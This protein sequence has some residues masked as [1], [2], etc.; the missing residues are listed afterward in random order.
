MLLVGGKA[1][2]SLAAVVQGPCQLPSPPEGLT[3]ADKTCVTL[4]QELS[5]IRAEQGPGP[6]ADRV[7]CWRMAH[8][9][10]WVGACMGALRGLGA[11]VAWPVICRTGSWFA[12]GNLAP[13]PLSGGKWGTCAIF[14]PPA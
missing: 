14:P 6:R 1:V 2:A 13:Q 4:R 7:V 8:M 5:I 3:A 9:H 12:G 10:M 11:L